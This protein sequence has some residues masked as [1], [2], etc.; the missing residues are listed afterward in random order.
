MWPYF[1]LLLIICVCALLDYGSIKYLQRKRQDSLKK[2]VHILF[3]I[4]S[5]FRYKIGVDYDNYISTFNWDIGYSVNELGFELLINMLTHI[6]A[7][8]QMMFLIM[9]IITQ[10]FVY[11]IFKRLDKGFWLATLVY[12]CFSTF[13]IASFNGSRQYVAIAIAIWALKYVYEKKI[14]K[15]SLAIMVAALSFHFSVLIFL[16]IYFFLQYDYSK[17]MIICQIVAVIFCARF[18]DI[19]VSYTPY[20][21]YMEREKDLVVHDTV[22]LFC[23]ISL[24]LA[25]T[26]HRYR[27]LAQDRIFTNMNLLCLFSLILVLVQ[28]SGMIKQM[29]LRINSYFLFAFL[30]IL[31]KMVY[32]FKSQPRRLAI[33]F[34][35]IVAITY[36][37]K[38]IIGSGA[39]Y[40]LVPYQMNFQL[41]K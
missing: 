36:L 10:Y 6:G 23:L 2:F 7:T 38:T 41:F 35:M 18:L 4:F 29:M 3:A 37:T 8:Y 16:P 15:Y 14:I 22:Y 19:I 13:Y 24:V 30:C 33:I 32:S 9:A 17:K 5:G 27:L 26:S 20:L 25:F 40:A 11:Q 28:S 12:Y 21:V 34:I 39:H 1:I 31:P